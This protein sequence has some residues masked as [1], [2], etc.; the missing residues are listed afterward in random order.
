MS[1]PNT[2]AYY[3][4]EL[5]AMVKKVI[6]KGHCGME[7]HGRVSKDIKKLPAGNFHLE[8]LKPGVDF[9]KLFFHCN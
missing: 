7:F 3:D 8:F 2:L 9:I 1:V 4:A 6:V 5:I